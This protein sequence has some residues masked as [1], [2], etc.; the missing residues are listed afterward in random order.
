MGH[1]RLPKRKG[2]LNERNQRANRAVREESARSTCA[3]L[4]APV[5]GEDVCATTARGVL[6][7]VCARRKCA[8]E[9]AAPV[10]S[11]TSGISAAKNAPRELRGAGGQCAQ[12]QRFAP[13][14][15]DLPMGRVLVPRHGSIKKSF[16][17]FFWI[18]LCHISILI[19]LLVQWLTESR[20]G[21]VKFRHSNREKESHVC[22]DRL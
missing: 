10:R 20:F 14:A 16:L 17:S 4:A 5:C 8:Q 11:G 12:H 1:G 6:G 18:V 13:Q 3:L 22:G 9:P 2:A 21:K 7:G 19:S 15:R